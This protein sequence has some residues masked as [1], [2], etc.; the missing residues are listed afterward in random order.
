MPYKPETLES[1]L[2]RFPEL[3][4]KQIEVLFKEY[5]FLFRITTPRRSRLGSFKGTRFGS[6]PV[7]QVNADLKQ[8]SFLLV[9]LHELAHLVV[10][11]H[12]GRKARPHGDEW[13]SAYRSLVQP[14]FIEKIF[15][16]ELEVELYKYFQK[17]PATFHRNSR[18]INV[19]AFYEGGKQMCVVEDVPMNSTFTLNNGRQFIKLLKLRTRYK[20]FCP[21]TKKFYLVPKSAQVID[22]DSKT[23]SVV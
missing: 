23:A 14:F 15:P 18:L 3:A 11:K 5:H 7:I 19:L 6:R 20:C 9:F 17:T 22:F 13:K 8:Y 1:V 10:M 2:L 4:R 12:Y 16:E 21:L